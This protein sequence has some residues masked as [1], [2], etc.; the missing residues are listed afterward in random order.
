MTTTTCLQKIRE[1]R[2]STHSDHQFEQ[3]VKLEFNR[4][5]VIGNWGTKR[6]YIVHD[7]DF[8]KNV[9]EYKFTYNGVEMSIAQY[10]L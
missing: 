10:F 8:E 7:I 2:S 5:S 3:A 9:S 1:L 6:T 4:K